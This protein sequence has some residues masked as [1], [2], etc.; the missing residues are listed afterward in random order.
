MAELSN[1]GLFEKFSNKPCLTLYNYDKVYECNGRGN[2]IKYYWHK[3]YLLPL[4]E[5]ERNNIEQIVINKRKNKEIVDE[6]IY[7]KYDFLEKLNIP[8]ILQS[9]G[10]STMDQLTYFI[11]TKTSEPFF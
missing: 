5:L 8:R 9:N 11:V 10:I 3:I 4:T 6:W 7:C 2:N 1:N